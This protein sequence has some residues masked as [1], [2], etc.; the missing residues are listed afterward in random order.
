MTITR[1]ILALA[2]LAALLVPARALA[3]AEPGTVAAHSEYLLDEYNIEVFGAPDSDRIAAGLTFGTS[4]GNGWWW[5]AGP[6]LSWIRWNVDAPNQDG[7]A[8]GGTFGAGFHPEKTVSPYAALAL[9]RAFNV[10]GIFDWQTT[11]NVGARVKVTQDPREY[12]SMTFS[13]YQASVFGGDGPHG[14]DYGIAVLYSAAFF[15]KR[16]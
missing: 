4:Y 16:K 14:T 12:F 15:A 13:V 9:D 10:S 11:L 5:N 6:R 8:V 7:M 1:R 2:L 3:Q